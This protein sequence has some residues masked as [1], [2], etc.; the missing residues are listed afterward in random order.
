MLQVN[1]LQRYARDGDKPTKC[2]ICHSCSSESAGRG[3]SLHIQMPSL[4]S[5]LGGVLR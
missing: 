4:S 1:P 2:N 5:D 3:M